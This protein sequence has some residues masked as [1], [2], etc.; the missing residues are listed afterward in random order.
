MTFEWLLTIEK[1]FYGSVQSKQ[2]LKEVHRQ[3]FLFDLPLPLYTHHCALLLL[4]IE[5]LKILVT[6]M[7]YTTISKVFEPGLAFLPV[8]FVGKLSWMTHFLLFQSIWHQS[9]CWGVS[10][11]LWAIPTEVELGSAA[12]WPQEMKMNY[13]ELAHRQTCELSWGQPLLPGLCRPCYC[14]K[15]VPY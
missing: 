10:T 2:W 15:E 9:D 13:P 4:T 14:L 5:A 6:L 8:V 3:Y 12:T 11:L 1:S 7:F